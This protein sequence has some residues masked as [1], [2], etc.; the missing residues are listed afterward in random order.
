MLAQGLPTAPK[1]SGYGVWL[2]KTSGDPVWL[3]YFQAV[4]TS[5]EVAAQS[6]LTVDPEGYERVI[7]TRQTGAEPKT[8]GTI[9]LEGAVQLNATG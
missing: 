3:G 1:G 8:P 2:T 5:G 9:Y 4:T 7:L 6:P